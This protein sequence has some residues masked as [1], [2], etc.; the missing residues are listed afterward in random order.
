AGRDDSPG[1]ESRHCRDSSPQ[2]LAAL[3]IAVRGFPVHR[4]DLDRRR[5]GAGG[6][7]LARRTTRPCARGHAASSRV[8]HP[9]PAGPI[10][11]TDLIAA[12]TRDPCSQGSRAMTSWLVSDR[13]SSRVSMGNRPARIPT[14]RFAERTAGGLVG[15]D[16][17]LEFLPEPLGQSLLVWGSQL[18]EIEKTVALLFVHVM[19]DGAADVFELVQVILAHGIEILECPHVGLGAGLLGVPGHAMCL[20]PKMH[21]C[22]VD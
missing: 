12:W 2:F 17:P 3:T 11:S 7:R 20:V 10:A 8:G 6:L 5:S 21:Q 18:F 9:S 4:M 13:C 16:V 19:G 14:S 15:T 22:R 1:V